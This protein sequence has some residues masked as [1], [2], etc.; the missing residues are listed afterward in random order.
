[1]GVWMPAGLRAP[2]D[3]ADVHC[4][5]CSR[6]G[7]PPVVGRSVVHSPLRRAKVLEQVL[8]I[9]LAGVRESDGAQ[10]CGPTQLVPA[11]DRL[12]YVL[13]PDCT[14]ARHARGAGPHAMA[15]HNP[16]EI[17][18]A[19]SWIEEERHSRSGEPDP[20]SAPVHPSARQGGACRFLKDSGPALPPLS[21]HSRERSDGAG[22][23]GGG[24][25]SRNT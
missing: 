21:R 9:P 13:L 12:P 6:R 24:G 25:V 20:T 14:F 23:G 5:I 2:G 15:A 19:S 18:A 3:L 1:M 17:R 22:D 7:A 16:G 11:M 10:E 4:V 8:Q